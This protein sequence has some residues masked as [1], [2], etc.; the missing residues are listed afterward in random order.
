MKNR[1]I[2]VLLAAPLLVAAA[3]CS[4]EGEGPTGAS[5][6]V[7]GAVYDT[8]GLPI[9]GIGVS[10]ITTSSGGT[11]VPDLRFRDTTDAD[12]RFSVLFDHYRPN[13]DTI[14]IDFLDISPDRTQRYAPD[15]VKVSFRGAVFTGGTGTY[16][17]EATREI[18][19]TLHR[20]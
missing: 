15:T 9:E 12:G 10:R 11:V 1:H 8:Y 2:T 16:D 13:I 17:G 5:Y 18:E 7:T 3:A 4:K 14:A 19:V 20:Q 6:R